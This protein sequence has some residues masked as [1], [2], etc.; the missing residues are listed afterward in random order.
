MKVIVTVMRTTFYVNKN[1]SI[2]S[3]SSGSIIS[4]SISSSNCYV[5]MYS[6]ALFALVS[7]LIT[8]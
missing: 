3:I 4:S 8:S 7:Y 5:K 6:N 1:S 2:S